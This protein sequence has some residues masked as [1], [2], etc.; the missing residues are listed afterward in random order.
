MQK[1]RP[2][3]LHRLAELTDDE[4]VS[5]ARLTYEAGADLNILQELTP[6][7]SC[8][9][10]C[11][12]SPE[13]GSVSPLGKAIQRGNIKF[14]LEILRIHVEFQKP[15]THFKQAFRISVIYRH[16]SINRELLRLTQ[17]HPT[18]LLD[19]DSQWN[20]TA[21]FFDDM[22]SIAVCLER[23]L[24]SECE[25]LAFHGENYTEAYRKTLDLLFSEFAR[26][27]AEAKLSKNLIEVALKSDNLVA[28]EAY[29][30]ALLNMGAD[31]N[32]H[33][34]NITISLPNSAFRQPL[35]V[36]TALTASL[37]H[38]SERCIIYFLS[39]FPE[40]VEAESLCFAKTEYVRLILEARP[41]LMVENLMG[42]NPLLD[43]LKKGKLESAK[44]IAEFCQPHLQ[45]FLCPE[46]AESKPSVF[47]SILKIW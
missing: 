17:A 14:A 31:I 8:D 45:Q 3:L 41:N 12:I 27:S 15:I 6:T 10:I 38:N 13:L 19:G 47:F 22:I 46:P 16:H 26:N 28:V 43:V 30:Q 21:E 29:V 39:H 5:L 23:E 2:T 9:G 44:I 20:P 37:S 11:E 18:L 35:K 32:T 1:A 36:K 40:L 42:Y 25:R 4:A 7:I 33:L 24:D 34:Y